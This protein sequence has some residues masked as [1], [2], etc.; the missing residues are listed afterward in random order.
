MKMIEIKHANSK[1]VSMCQKQHGVA[2]SE[3]EAGSGRAPGKK[4]TAVIIIT[5][6]VESINNCE[7]D[8]EHNQIYSQSVVPALNAHKEAAQHHQISSR[9]F[10]MSSF[11]SFFFRAFSQKDTS[12]AG[13]NKTFLANK[14]T[15]GCAAAAQYKGE[16]RKLKIMIFLQ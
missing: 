1:C 3:C 2:A 5:H 15:R 7:R 8:M 11:N 10:M 16:K 9:C 4:Y 6:I 12:R 13:E 14:R